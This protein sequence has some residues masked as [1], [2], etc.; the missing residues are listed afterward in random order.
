MGRPALKREA[1]AYLQSHYAISQRRACSVVRISR[2]VC[3]YQSIRDSHDAIRLRMKELAKVRVRYGYRRLHI[4]LRRE[5]HQVNKKLIYRLYREEGLQLR[6]KRPRRRKMSATRRERALVTA[7]NQAW[8]MDFVADQLADGRKLRCLTVVDVFTREA[9]AIVVGSRL[10]AEDVV[11]TCNAIRA[12]RG[13]PERIF[14]DNGSEFSGRMLDLWA[15]H[16]HVTLD[17]SRPGKPTDNAVCES[18]NGSFRDECLNTHWFTNLDDARKQ[19]EAWRLDFN[20]SRPHM[21]LNG[22]SPTEYARQAAH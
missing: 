1:V 11:A 14:V 13:A 3:R 7:R 22:A 20:E 15:F 17:F 21:A 8:A 16:H 12:E 19:I 18:F 9:L 10:R 2:S 4:L 5:G 6:S